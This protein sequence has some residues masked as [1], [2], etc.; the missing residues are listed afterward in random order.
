MFLKYLSVQENWRD[1][2][3]LNIPSFNVISSIIKVH[4]TLLLWLTATEF[5]VSPFTERKRPKPFLPGVRGRLCK[6]GR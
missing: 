5:F 4:D 2:Y 1:F 3:H 6:P